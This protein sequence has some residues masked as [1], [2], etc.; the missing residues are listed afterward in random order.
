MKTAL[1]AF[2]VG[3]YINLCQFMTVNKYIIHV[4]LS[5]GSLRVLRNYYILVFFA[6]PLL[7]HRYQDI[8]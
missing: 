2:G 3:Q 6:V 7:L 5:V 4:F 8:S 1:L